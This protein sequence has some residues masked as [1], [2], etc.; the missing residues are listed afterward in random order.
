MIS[1][2]TKEIVSTTMHARI[3][4]IMIVRDRWLNLCIDVNSF[5]KEC[6]SRQAAYGTP[7][8]QGNP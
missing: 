1:E 7:Q 8:I 4:N 6:F 3:P 2:G 5:V